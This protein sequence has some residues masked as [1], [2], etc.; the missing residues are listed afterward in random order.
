MKCCERT[1]LEV[2][3]LSKVL[4]DQLLEVD[5]WQVRLQSA[6]VQR[7]VVAIEAAHSAHVVSVRPVRGGEQ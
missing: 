3:P 4:D 5:A 1:V 2:A 6:H 7:P